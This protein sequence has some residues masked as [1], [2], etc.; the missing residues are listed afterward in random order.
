[1]RNRKPRRSSGVHST[2]R[3]RDGDRVRVNRDG[4]LGR[5][6]GR[7]KVWCVR[8]DVDVRFPVKSIAQLSRHYYYVVGFALRNN[9]ESLLRAPPNLKGE[10]VE[11]GG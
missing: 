8:C 6:A 7:R 1:M 10:I 11:C 5:M 4:R 2:E 3:E 9:Q